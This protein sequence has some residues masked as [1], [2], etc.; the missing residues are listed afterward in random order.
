MFGGVNLGIN[1]IGLNFSVII[2][3]IYFGGN[4][5]RFPEDFMFEMTNEEFINWRTQF[6]TS[7][8]DKMG[9]PYV[10]FCFTKQGVTMLSSVLYSERALQLNIQI[11]RIFTKI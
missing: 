1:F 3:V 8:T 11:V 6:A 5:T 4:V 2:L 10:L 7:N 9:P